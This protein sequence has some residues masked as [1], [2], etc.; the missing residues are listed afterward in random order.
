MITNPDDLIPDNLSDYAADTDTLEDAL[1]DQPEAI[2]IDASEIL[3]I[4]EFLEHLGK[5]ET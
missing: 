1:S 3:T 2:H 4:E 5:D